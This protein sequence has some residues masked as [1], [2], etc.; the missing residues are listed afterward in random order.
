MVLIP[1]RLGMK[2]HLYV[3]ILAPLLITTRFKAVMAMNL[4]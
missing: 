3:Y 2:M 1:H 4:S